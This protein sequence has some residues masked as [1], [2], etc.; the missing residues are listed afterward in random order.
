MDSKSHATRKRMLSNIYSKNHVISSPTTPET[1]K[2]II[3]GRLLPLVQRN[4]EVGKP[5][6]TLS[7][8]YA[9]SMDS[10][11]AYQY[12]LSLAS[13][14][15]EDTQQRDWYLRNFFS[16]RP[17][18]F[19]ITEVPG[20]TALARKFGLKLFPEHASNSIKELE[21]WTLGICDKAEKQLSNDVEFE[22]AN[23]P[24][25]FAQHRTSLQNQSRDLKGKLDP[26]LLPIEQPYPARLEI[27]SDMHCHSAAAIE[28]SGDT[29]AYVY[30]E[31]SR[32]PD[33]QKRLREE[34]S[35]VTP[36]LIFPLPEGQ[37]LELPKF[38][39]IDALPLLDA[40]IQETLR[41][42]PAVPGG[43]PRVTPSSGCKLAGYNNIPAGVRVQA[44]AYALHKN[45]EVFP[46]PDE[47]KPERW[48]NAT[49]TELVEMRHWFWAWGSG[50]RMC[51]GRNFAM[52]CKVYSPDSTL[53]SQKL[54]YRVSDEIRYCKY[55]HEL[56]NFDSRHGWY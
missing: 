45:P 24:V 46:E 51:I 55:L 32:R 5:I 28:T 2:A 26:N 22:A 10:F 6:E 13:N 16:P 47:W 9:Y 40:I 4:V 48:L 29:L 17:H 50:G 41:K 14:F 38:K 23:T 8:S 53:S 20:F 35:S 27:A 44:S 1:T 15:I 30:Y 19:W 36:N 7:L 3:F 56:H 21:D 37:T 18:L 11:M 39:N 42:W 49:P 12:G 43:Q 54:T 33:L 34:V 52:H 25:V 31:L